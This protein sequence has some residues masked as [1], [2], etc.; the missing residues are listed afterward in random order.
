[1]PDAENIAPDWSVDTI[2][3]A[4]KRYLTHM[5][6]GQCVGREIIVLSRSESI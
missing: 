1:M 3:F 2:C 5:R 6:P 4:G